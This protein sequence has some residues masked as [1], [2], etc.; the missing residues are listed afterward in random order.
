MVGLI[1][2][3]AYANNNTTHVTGPNNFTAGLTLSFA[4]DKFQEA[5]DVYFD[6]IL[7]AILA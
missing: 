1:T 6:M 7:N 3:F 4:K 5:K 2:K